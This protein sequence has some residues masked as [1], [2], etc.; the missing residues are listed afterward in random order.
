[1]VRNLL[2]S[3]LHVLPSELSRIAESDPHTRDYTLDALPGALSQIVACFSV[4]R[5]RISAA[6]VCSRDRNQVLKAASKARNRPRGY[7]RKRSP[8]PRPWDHSRGLGSPVAP[9]CAAETPRPAGRQFQ[10]WSVLAAMIKSL[11][12]NPLIL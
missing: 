11:R 8:P 12:C 7:S 9:A 1:V 4:Y 2:S 5:T 3:E 10:S 6:G